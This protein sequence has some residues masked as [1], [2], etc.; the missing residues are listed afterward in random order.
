MPSRPL[1]GVRVL[2]FSHALAGP[3]CTLLLADYGAEVFKLESRAGDMAGGWGQPFRGGGGPF[4]L[5]LIPGGGF[6]G[7]VARGRFGPW[8]GTTVCRRRG[9]FLP[10][11]EPRQARAVHR[12]KETGR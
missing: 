9:S 12:F 4:F 6:Q 8:L 1:D 3:F 2:D 11:L 10:W 7:G 5:G